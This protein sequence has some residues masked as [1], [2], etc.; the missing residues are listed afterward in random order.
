M[1][2]IHVPAGDGVE[3]LR[4][5]EMAPAIESGINAFRDAVYGGAGQLSIR[6]REV[7]RMRIAQINQ[8][9]I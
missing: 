1:A 8:C 2:L 6:E 7:A 9:D 4:M 5:W 3:R